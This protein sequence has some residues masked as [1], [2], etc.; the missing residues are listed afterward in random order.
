MWC[1]WCVNL[2]RKGAWMQWYLLGGRVAGWTLQI[3]SLLVTSP[4]PPA[5][6]SAKGG[7]AEKINIRDL[8]LL[9]AEVAMIV[10]SSLA[11]SLHRAATISGA[12]DAHAEMRTPSLATL[13]FILRDLVAN[14]SALELLYLRMGVH[15]VPWAGLWAGRADPTRRSL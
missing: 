9:V 7:P 11:L 13:H 5:S 4:T 14:Y 8:D 12:Q 2:S 6:E 3:G 10:Q 1:M 15:K